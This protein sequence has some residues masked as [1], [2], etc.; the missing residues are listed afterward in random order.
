MEIIVDY[1]CVEMEVGLDIN[2]RN[3]LPI[4]AL[5]FLLL[6]G[7]GCDN[8]ASLSAQSSKQTFYGFTLGMTY[9]EATAEIRSLREQGR[10]G[11][12]NAGQEITGDFPGATVI[13]FD[14][15][16]D[17]MRTLSILPSDTK[18]YFNKKLLF[19]I[20]ISYSFKSKYSVNIADVEASDMSRLFG[21]KPQ[22]EISTD[23][24]GNRTR[25]IYLRDSLRFP[26]VR[27]T[28]VDILDGDFKAFAPDITILDDFL[29]RKFL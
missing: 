14:G 2:I 1:R 29:Y 23:S 10:M 6:L 25:F 21:V 19:A 22:E 18:L 27:V 7:Y 26:K 8:T 5:L 4:S 9:D 16:F 12:A 15:V 3:S 20:Q 11:E 17:P 13:S 24:L 28:I